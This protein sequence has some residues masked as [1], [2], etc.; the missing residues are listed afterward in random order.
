MLS[1]RRCSGG[2][3]NAG[4]SP[5]AAPY[6]DPV[7]TLHVLRA[8]YRCQR[9]SWCR[10]L[11]MPQST[12]RDEPVRFRFGRSAT[13]AAR[14]TGLRSSHQHGTSNRLYQALGPGVAP[15]PAQT[16]KRRATREVQDSTSFAIPHAEKASPPTSAVSRPAAFMAPSTRC[17]KRL[18]HPRQMEV[19]V[20]LHDRR[21]RRL[22]IDVLCVQDGRP[23]TSALRSSTLTTSA[24]RS[25]RRSTQ[26]PEPGADQE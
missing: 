3:R 4:R 12:L 8:L 13:S 10:R 24:L 15:T 2:T 14:K 7:S 1:T 9:D 19:A 17:G 6:N 11:R 22:G 25:G 26:R 21:G 23:E 5:G 20:G 16:S 18:S